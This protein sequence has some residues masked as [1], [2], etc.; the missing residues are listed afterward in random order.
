MET[1]MVLAL[2][3]RSLVASMIGPGQQRERSG[4]RTRATSRLGSS[5]STESCERN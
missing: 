2:R 4:T 3:V 5:V 1:S